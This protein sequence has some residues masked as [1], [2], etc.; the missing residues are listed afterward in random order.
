VC[1]DIALL[2]LLYSSTIAIPSSGSVP[3]KLYQRLYFMTI[4]QCVIVS[5]K[6]VHT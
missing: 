4:Q 2:L 3:Y 5:K 6:I 1:N